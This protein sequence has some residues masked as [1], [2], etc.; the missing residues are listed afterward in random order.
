MVVSPLGR[1]PRCSALAR[2]HGWDPVATAGSYELFLLVVLPLPWPSEIASHT[3]LTGVAESLEA[4]AL[5]RWRI[6]ALVPAPAEA[7]TRVVLYRRHP[8]GPRDGYERF[9]TTYSAGGLTRAVESLLAG[10]SSSPGGTELLLCTHGSRDVCCGSLGASLWGEVADL[11]PLGTKA[12]RTSHTGGH[13]FAPTAITFPDGRFWAYLDGPVVRAILERSKSPA[14]LA[15]HYRGS[16]AVPSAP[17]QLAE[18]EVLV[19]EGWAFTEGTHSFE[20]REDP[21]GTITASVTGERPVGS[22]LSYEI[23]LS[24]S[25]TLPIP[26]CGRPLEEAR[27]SEPRWSV[28]SVTR[29]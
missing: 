12:W 22:R 15:A 20:S 8:Q 25:G 29:R 9:E 11:L 26:D 28:V 16:A 10:D 21:D 2:A 6:Q 27:K 4:A 24:P 7:A 18:R 19:R 23:V 13:R 5:G 17:L 3:A 1:S 14:D